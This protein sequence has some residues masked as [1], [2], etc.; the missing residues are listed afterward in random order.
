MNDIRKQLKKT[1]VSSLTQQEKNFVWKQVSLSMAA[2]PHKDSYKTKVSSIL[3]RS[4][5]ISII[6]GMT[7]GTASATDSSKPG[8][9][10]FPFERAVENIQ[11]SMTSGE[12]KDELKVKFALERVDEVKTIFSEVSTKS[13]KEKQKEVSIKKSEKTKVADKQ[14]E[15]SEGKVPTLKDAGLVSSSSRTESEN[16]VFEKFE[17]KLS[18]NELTTEKSLESQ[19]G[20]K[21]SD[22]DKKKIEVAL[23]TALDFL[24]DV[25]GELSEQGNDKAASSIDGLVKDLNGEI[26]TLPKNIT[27]EVK[28]SPSKQKVQFEVTSEDSKESVKITETPAL[29]KI[30]NKEPISKETTMAT[31]TTKETKMEIKDGVLKINPKTEEEVP[32]TEEEKQTSS[33][34]TES[35]LKDIKKEGV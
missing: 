15:N 20:M 29:E 21:I 18:Q 26:E 3:K 33:T 28:L 11:I 34:T 5:A 6:F 30:E 23:G 17:N 1:Q 4:V 35:V 10:L 22:T 14:I 9:L 16:K 7:M 13:A 12:K 31:S 24:G 25:K 32:K 8:D 19:D 27:F 2:T